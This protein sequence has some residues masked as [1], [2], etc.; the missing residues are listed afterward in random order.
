MKK[1]KLG[2]YFL[3]LTFS[4]AIMAELAEY[5]EHE[6]RH[7]S[8][9]IHGLESIVGN[10]GLTMSSRLARHVELIVP[11]EFYSFQYSL[12]GFIAIKSAS[13]FVNVNNGKVPA[14][15]MSH[16]QSGVGARIFFSPSALDS[17]FFLA[18]ILK[19]GWI[20]HS[21]FKSVEFDNQREVLDAI[22]NTLYRDLPISNHFALTPQLI[23]GYQ[24]ISEGGGLVQLACYGSYVYA[25]GADTVF[26]AS[27]RFLSS[28]AVSRA[29]KAKLP[30]D[31]IEAYRIFATQMNGWHAGIYLN[32]GFAI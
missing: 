26:N 11:F 17:G 2:L 27:Q 6:D 22:A 8:L 16:L 9:G 18:P 4:L 19:A 3:P 21:D 23:L 5:Q 29:N 31:I 20:E 7:F 24:W 14:L 32:F 28:A 30:K 12:P 1:L 25:P 15:T 10:Y 13:S